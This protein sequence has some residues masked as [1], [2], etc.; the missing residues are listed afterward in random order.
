MVFLLLSACGEDSNSPGPSLIECD[1]EDLFGPEGGTIEITDVSSEFNGLRIVIPADALDDCRSLYVDEGFVSFLPKGC[2]GYPDQDAQFNLMTGG[3]EPY[4]LEL[5]FHFPVTGMVIEPGE[6]PCAFGYDDRAEK[7]KVILPDRFDGTTMT[8]KTTYHDTWMWGKIDLDVVSSENL[9]GAMKEQYGEETWNS[10]IGGIVEAIDVLETLYVDR[11]CQTWTRM[12]DVDLPDLIQTQ[13]NI[14]VSY[15]SQIE[16]C[17]T[18]NLFSLE[19]GLDLSGYL[20]AQTVILTADL[21]D[22]F[23]GDWA[24]FMPFLS[25]LDF[26]INMERFIAISFIESQECDYPCVTR[27]LGLDV[28]STYALHLVYMVTQYM[29]TLA[30]DGDFWVDC[31]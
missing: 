30:I 22:L 15:Q 20:L 25:H 16:K 31:P 24:G 26:F 13:K 19:F 3:D 7:W 23:I 14:L 1:G 9:V 12:R 18:C 29:V 2:I 11:T 8:V 27:E 6:T 28:Y 21:W 10:V 17:G 4:G 5:E